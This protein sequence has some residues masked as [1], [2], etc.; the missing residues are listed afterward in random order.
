M[1]CRNEQP[2]P[3]GI[4]APPRPCSKHL[5]FMLG[6]QELTSGMTFRAIAS[7]E[8]NPAQGC[9]RLGGAKHLAAGGA[10]TDATQS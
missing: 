1:R 4:G 2:A 6:F 3:P 9:G 7:G 5:L 8:A 10:R